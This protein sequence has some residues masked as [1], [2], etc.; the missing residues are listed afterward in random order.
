[1][2]T[3]ARLLKLALLLSFMSLTT[4]GRDIPQSKSTPVQKAE[5]YFTT[6]DKKQTVYMIP[7]Q[8]NADETG[9][10]GGCV[11]TLK[12]SDP[13]IPVIKIK[14]CIGGTP[15]NL[16]DLDNDGKDEIG[17]LRDWF[18][19]CWRSFEVYTFKNGKWEFAVPPISTHCNQWEANLKPIVK[20]PQ[21]K[22][23]V[24]ITYSV[25]VDS[26]I[27]VKTKIIPVK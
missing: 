27:A 12:F 25:L 16:G 8:L 22:G 6:K 24:K 1:M 26:G 18:T 3:G 23:F 7:P 5:G 15:V 9:C 13:S 21:K 11:V 20:A 10:I 2:F 17:I 19:S 14:D 4:V